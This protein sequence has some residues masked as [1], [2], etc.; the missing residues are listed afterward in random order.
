[1]LEEE[2]IEGNGYGATTNSN[3][4]KVRGTYFACLHS[5]SNCLKKSVSI[6][7][8]N[9]V[10]VF[11]LVCEDFWQCSRGLLPNLNRPPTLSRTL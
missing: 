11:M 4:P 9:R 3:I 5:V 2:A 6:K 10:G 7:R 1:M 8:M